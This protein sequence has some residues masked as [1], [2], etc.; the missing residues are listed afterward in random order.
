[1]SSTAA[2]YKILYQNDTLYQLPEDR[3]KSTVK[4][5]QEIVE[6]TVAPIA[7]IPK[8]VE[9]VTPAVVTEPP[10]YRMDSGTKESFPVLTHKILILMDEPNQKEMIT[11]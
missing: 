5:E 1:M 9:V 7:D 8:K 4:V 11:R 10:V 6:K 2:F 3:N